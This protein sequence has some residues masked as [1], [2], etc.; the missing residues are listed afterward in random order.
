MILRSRLSPAN[1][2]IWMALIIAVWLLLSIVGNSAPAERSYGEVLVARGVTVNGAPA[3]SGLTLISGGRV[4]TG[5]DGRATI[6]LGR[7]GLVKLGPE[8]EMVLRFTSG[9]IRGELVAGWA[10]ISAPKGVPVSVITRDGVA[11]TSGSSSS[12]LTVDLT[13]GQTRVESSNDAT[14]ISGSVSRRVSASQS[15]TVGRSTNDVNPVFNVTATGAE[16]GLQGPRGGLLAAFGS[17][18]RG[19][20]RTIRLDQNFPMPRTYARNLVRSPEDLRLNSTQQQVTCPPSPCPGCSISPVLVKARARCTTYF[21]V[22]LNNVNVTS[23]VSVRPFFSNACFSI[24][25]NYPTQVTIPP[26]GST[27]YNI[28]GRFCPNNAGSLPQNSQI[29]IETNTCGKKNVPV[30][31]AVPCR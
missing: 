14:V 23:T 26:G 27:F 11:Q 13:A 16:A 19:A 31:W 30:E 12:M 3:A 9:E 15:L 29:V 5:D 20:V 24:F 4:K 28:D 25:P 17:S 1:P 7:L 8:A 21:I 6:N 2:L 10:V 18:L 22:K